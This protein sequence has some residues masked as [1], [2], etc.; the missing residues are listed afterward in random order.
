METVFLPVVAVRLTPLL[1]TSSRTEKSLKAYRVP[2]VRDRTVKEIGPLASG[3]KTFILLLPDCRMK[4]TLSFTWSHCTVINFSL[5]WTN[6]KFSAF[7]GT[8]RQRGKKETDRNSI[9]QLITSRKVN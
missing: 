5:V 2:G 4:L 7:G 1:R 6:L 9:Q 3:G 8:E